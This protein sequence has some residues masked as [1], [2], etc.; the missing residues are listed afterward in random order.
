MQ[1]KNFKIPRKGKLYEIYDCRNINIREKIRIQNKLNSA[2]NKDKLNF[3]SNSDLSIKF[4][5]SMSK[6]SS[7]VEYHSEDNY[8]FVGDAFNIPKYQKEP[9]QDAFFATDKGV[10]V[11]DGVGSWSSYGI[12]CSLFSRTLMK[13]CQKFIQRV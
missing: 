11:S 7:L 2:N 9:T 5:S 1:L 3:I 8:F 13:E 4:S 10:G 6:N 12:D